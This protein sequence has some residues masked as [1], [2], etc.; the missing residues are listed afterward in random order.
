MAHMADWEKK[1]DKL[2]RKRE[3]A[4]QVSRFTEKEDKRQ[5]KELERIKE[6]QRDV[7]LPAEVQR[8]IYMVQV[9]ACVVVVGLYVTSMVFIANGSM[10]AACESTPAV[11]TALLVVLLTTIVGVGSCWRQT[12]VRKEVQQEAAAHIRGQ[13]VRRQTEQERAEQQKQRRAQQVKQ[14]KEQ[15]KRRLEQE[16]AARQ[17]VQEIARMLRRRREE[18]EAEEARAAATQAVDD[19]SR[20]THGWSQRQY[21]ELRNAVVKYPESWSHARKKRWE[22]IAEEVNGQNARNCEAAF[23]RLEEEGRAAA[24]EAKAEGRKSV[25]QPAAQRHS[26]EDDLDWMGDDTSTQDAAAT[27]D[28]EAPDDSE[29]DD[30]GAEERVRMVVELEPEHK[31]TEI[32]LEKIKTMQGCA[33]VQLEVLHLQVSCADCKASGQ[34]FL[35]GADE[36]AAEAK[37]WCEGCSG[38]I[39]VRL[40]PTLV[41]Q[42]STRL[43]YL[44][45]VRCNVV[46]VLPSVLMTTCEYCD[47]ENIHKQEFVRNRVIHGTCTKCH[48]KYAFGAEAIK[49]EQ[50]TPCDM[51]GRGGTSAPKSSST[52]CSDSGDPMDEIAEELRW[53]RKK[54]KADPKQQ[55]IQLGRPLPQMGAC[56]HFK[57]SYKW[58]RF[59]CCGRAFPCPEC[60]AE[61]GCPAAALGSHATR[62][63]CG[64]CSMEQ[65]YSP[66]RPCEKCGFAMQARG[67]SHWEDGGGTRNLAVM[68]SKDAK[69]FKGGLRQSNSKAKTSSAKGDR[70]GAKAKSKR[71]YAQKFGKNG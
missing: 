31:G 29:E 38:I 44:D 8:K 58:Y 43:C 66:A 49:I 24:A 62:M 33:I 57:K 27:V 21:S 39:S 30:D 10:P 59:G 50:I 16:A 64:K 18:R 70:V 32:R 56:S 5:K 40:R 17:Q 47:A 42:C 22:M 23:I 20:D 45:C 11:L 34:L 51:G 69:K 68:S 67:S 7:Q 9:V 4:R 3:S 52:S 14:L 41:H 36:D 65:S 71:E 19:Q 15:Q 54:A 46:D 12:L 26:F 60:H 55:M 28:F 1:K 35:S 13:L 25:A 53:L 2:D 48:S 6:K 37:T 63:I 61:S